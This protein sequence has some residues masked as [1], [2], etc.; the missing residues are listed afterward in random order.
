MKVLF[1]TNVYVSEALVGGLAERLI[2][3]TL[4]ARWRIQVSDYI[5]R[6]TERVLQDKFGFS[7]RL[8]E[9]TKARIERRGILIDEPDSRHR[10]ISDAKDSPILRAAVSAGADYLVSDDKHFLEM[11]RYQGI[12]ILSMKQFAAVLKNEGMLRE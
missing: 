9:L 4:L 10:V 11:G 6:E 8:A 12:Q 5:M 2:E 3:A 7:P 1:D